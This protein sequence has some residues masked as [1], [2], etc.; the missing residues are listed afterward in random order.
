MSVFI[1]NAA[2]LS[3]TYTKYTAILNSRK[4]F[5]SFATKENTEIGY[6]GFMGENKLADTFLSNH[7]RKKYPLDLK[8][9][10]RVEM[11]CHGMTWLQKECRL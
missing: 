8:S 5:S 9:E 10:D 7:I 2:I 1:N 6:S 4:A 3:R 11:S